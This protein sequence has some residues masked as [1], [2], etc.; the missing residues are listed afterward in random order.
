MKSPFFFLI[1]PVGQE[2]NNTIEIAG[3]KIVINSTVENHKHVNRF[4]EIIQVPIHYNGDIKP[5]DT[6]IVHH[7][8][9]RIYYD[10]KGR[11]KKS[12]NFFK[13]DIYFID[14][15]QFYMYHNGDEWCSVEDW[16]FVKPIDKEN[17]YLYEEGLEE[18]TG[19]VVY[20]NKTL[21][22]RKVK[23]GSLIKFSSNSEYEFVVNNELLYRMNTKD[24]IALI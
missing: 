4:A 10:V 12:P 6:I 2:Y 5:G 18:N 13:D 3:Q 21:Y 7:N 16:C 20:S 14:S 17:T 22:S 24:V 23:N 19:T 9:F 15:F 8:V 1:K 11:A